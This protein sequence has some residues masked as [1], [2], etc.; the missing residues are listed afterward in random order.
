MDV[1]FS[2]LSPVIDNKSRHNIVKLVCGSTATLIWRCYEEINY[3]QLDR[4]THVYLLLFFIRTSNF[5]AEVERS[6]ILLWSEAE[7]VLNMVLNLHNSMLCITWWLWWC[8]SYHWNRIDSAQ[9]SQSRNAIH[10]KNP[11]KFILKEHRKRQANS[12]IRK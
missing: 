9:R 6:Y 4:K 10:D 12:W 1:S 3:Q 7:S 5:G 8:G 2:C 11:S